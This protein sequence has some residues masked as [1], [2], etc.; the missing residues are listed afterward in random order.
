VLELGLPVVTMI[1]ANAV[2]SIASALQASVGIGL[3]LLAVPLRTSRILTPPRTPTRS[4]SRVRSIVRIGETL[5]T[6]ARGRP[7]SSRRRRPFPGMAPSR[8]FDV[9]AAT[10]VVEMT[11]RLNRSCW[12]TR[13]GRQVPS[14]G[15]WGRDDPT[16][17]FGVARRRARAHAGRR[18]QLCAVAGFSFLAGR[19]VG[20]TLWYQ[21]DPSLT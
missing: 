14:Q 12:A 3:A 9:T 18:A 7:A 2:M 11:L 13:A 16:P 21:V 8:R 10:P 17:A 20:Q 4:T 5:T 19:R 6:L 1:A 15:V